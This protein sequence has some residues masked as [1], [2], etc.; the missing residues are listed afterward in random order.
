MLT[1]PV[2]MEKFDSNLEGSGFHL[3]FLISLK[4]VY[5]VLH[6]SLLFLQFTTFLRLVYY[7]LC[8]FPDL[9]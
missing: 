1:L 8:C 6:Q 9:C 7:S 3:L 5:P 4:S 2:A